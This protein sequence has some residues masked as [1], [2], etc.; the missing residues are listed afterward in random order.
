MCIY[1]QLK[2][3]KFSMWVSVL[4]TGVRGRRIESYLSQNILLLAIVNI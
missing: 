3:V 1:N 4:D 2:Y